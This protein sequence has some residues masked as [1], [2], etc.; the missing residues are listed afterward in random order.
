MDDLEMAMGCPHCRDLPAIPLLDGIVD[1]VGQTTRL[2]DEKH[3]RDEPLALSAEIHLLT[4]SAF[5]GCLVHHL[6]EMHGVP[7]AQAAILIGRS[8]AKTEVILGWSRR[9][10]EA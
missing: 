3:A 9:P 5:E 8:I 1:V 2:L 6:V 4:G 10:V 7:V